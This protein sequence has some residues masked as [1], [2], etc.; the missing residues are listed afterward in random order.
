MSGVLKFA[1]LWKFNVSLTE[2]QST[3]ELDQT[4]NYTWIN[5]HRISRSQTDARRRCCRRWWTMPER[6]WLTS[7]CRTMCTPSAPTFVGS[8]A[9]LA[10]KSKRVR[11]SVRGLKRK[12]IQNKN[13]KLK[14][15]RFPFPAG[16]VVWK[17]CLWDK[18]D[19][20][21]RL[22]LPVWEIWE[23]SHKSPAW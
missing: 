9:C 10:R 2:L 3:S 4:R 8:D 1:C 23:Y 14:F 22:Y 12:L 18:L 16:F 5:F 7:S 11:W 13:S 17:I 15:S 21:S 20:L 19:L 6:V